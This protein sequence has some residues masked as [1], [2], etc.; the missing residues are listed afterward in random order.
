MFIARIEYLS[1][2]QTWLHLALLLH[3]IAA[4]HVLMHVNKNNCE[5]LL[6]AT[7]K[8]LIIIFYLFRLITT[9]EIWIVTFS[10][11]WHWNRFVRTIKVSLFFSPPQTLQRNT[12][13]RQYKERV[14]VFSFAVFYHLFWSIC[15]IYY[16][17]N[18][19]NVPQCSCCKVPP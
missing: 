3:M 11:H 2:Q 7:C 12:I 1:L 9:L 18:L 4:N 8:P 6:S 15:G 17:K 13:N 16:N 10:S 19:L 14:D 5:L